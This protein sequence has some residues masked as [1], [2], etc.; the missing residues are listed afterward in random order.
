MNLSHISR[1]MAA[2][3][4]VLDSEAGCASMGELAAAVKAA[5]LGDY[6]SEYPLLTDDDAGSGLDKA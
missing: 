6:T 4:A 3:I 1:L 2:A 5:G